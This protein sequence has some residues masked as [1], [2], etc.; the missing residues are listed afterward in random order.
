MIITPPLKLTDPIGVKKDFELFVKSQYGG[1]TT[2]SPVSGVFEK[3]EMLRLK[4]D[5]S[6]YN[7]SL[8]TDP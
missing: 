6:K 8:A 4:L 3:I 1:E 2:W 7:I 5:F